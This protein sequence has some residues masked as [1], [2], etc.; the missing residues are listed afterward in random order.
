MEYLHCDNEQQ[1]IT[2][3]NYKIMNSYNIYEENNEATILYHAIAR[4][5]D[6]VMELAKEAGIDMDGLSIELERSNVKD[7]LGK[8]LSARIEDALIY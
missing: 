3:K 2:N 7:Q 1:I 5:E 4:D 6:Q 8:P